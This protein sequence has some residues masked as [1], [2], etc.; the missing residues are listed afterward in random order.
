MAWMLCEELLKLAVV[1]AVELFL[2]VCKGIVVTSINQCKIPRCRHPRADSMR[3]LCIQCYSK[4][5]KKVQ[6]GET[7]WDRLVEM[8]LCDNETDPFDD[9]YSRA[10]DHKLHSD[11]R[12]H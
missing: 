10:L 12:D 5:K 7:S 11:R 4:A 2:K 8:G 6:S 3:G 1:Y 9:A